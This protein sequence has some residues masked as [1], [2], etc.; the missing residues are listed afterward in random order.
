MFSYRDA[1]R[2][3]NFISEPSGFLTSQERRLSWDLIGCCVYEVSCLS[4]GIQAYVAGGF[5]CQLNMEEKIVNSKSEFWMLW[6][7]GCNSHLSPKRRFCGDWCVGTPLQRESVSALEPWVAFYE[8]L[9]QVWFFIY[10]KW[11]PFV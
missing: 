6:N 5:F 11:Y 3:H 1:S 8:L 10:Q 9:Y 2:G 7:Q 4:S